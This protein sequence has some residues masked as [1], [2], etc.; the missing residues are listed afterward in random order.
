V[1]RFT[2]RRVGRLVA[3]AAV[4]AM[5]AVPAAEAGRTHG[6]PTAAPAPSPSVWT[7]RGYEIDRLGPKHVALQHPVSPPPATV[8]KVVRP[9]GFHWGD[10]G[11]GAAVAAFVLGGAAG[12]ALV[13]TRRRLRPV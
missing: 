4:T 5:V 1:N 10:A 7:A 2:W 13:A 6:G 12:L 3:T 11:V 8:V 9:A